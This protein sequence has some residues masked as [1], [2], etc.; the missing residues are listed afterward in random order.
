MRNA[1]LASPVAL[2]LFASDAG[3]RLAGAENRLTIEVVDEA[4]P[5]GATTWGAIKQMYE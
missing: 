5:V 2:A 4:L 3:V 1:R